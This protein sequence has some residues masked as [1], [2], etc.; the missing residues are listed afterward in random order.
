MTT[1]SNTLALALIR[2]VLAEVAPDELETFDLIG[3]GILETAET[4]GGTVEEPKFGEMSD[5][6]LQILIFLIAEPVRTKAYEILASRQADWAAK[7]LDHLRTHQ[8]RWS[9]VE[10]SRKRR[11]FEALLRRLEAWSKGKDSAP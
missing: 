4:G 10:D 2:D 6:I 9:G 7:L 3:E 1:N 11:A 5:L 8:D